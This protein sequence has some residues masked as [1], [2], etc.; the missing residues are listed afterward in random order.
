[1]E[2][3]MPELRLSPRGAFSTF[4][5]FRNFM[6]LIREM[7]FV[8]ER[9][10]AEHLPRVLIIA[11]DTESG[12]QL[13][14]AL[15]GSPGTAPVTV[16]TLDAASRSSD[17]FDVVIVHNPASKATYRQART[18][19]GSDALRVFETHAEGDEEKWQEH[20]RHRIASTL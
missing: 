13:G 17:A 16:W 3:G 11:T 6:T 14:D 8:E 19:A 5:S 4:N 9:E 15:T 7:S 20:L 12:R 18:A 10:Q 1:M 2:Q